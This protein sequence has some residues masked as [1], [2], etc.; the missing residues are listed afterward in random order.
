M[1]S[2]AGRKLFISDRTQYYKDYY[3]N[4]KLR[5]KECYERKKKKDKEN[6]K[7]YYIRYWQ[8]LATR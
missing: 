2:G 8:Q 5:Y 3:N 1:P 4:N 6:D 7:E